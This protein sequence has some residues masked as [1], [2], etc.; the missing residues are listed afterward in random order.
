MKLYTLDNLFAKIIFAVLLL[1]TSTAF[2]Q[3]TD[4][5][6]EL[7][8]DYISIYGES[9]GDGV[10]A[11]GTADIEKVIPGFSTEEILSDLAKGKNI[12]SV[13]E[14]IGKGTELFVA[15]IKRTLKLLI[16]IPA[17][18][19]LGSYI[20]SMQD[21]LQIK[22]AAQASFFTCYCLIAGI[23]AAAFF[24]VVGCG[25]EIINNVSLF[26][27]VLVPVVLVSL[28]SSGAIVSA[29]MFEA[30]LV[31]VIEITQWLIETVFVPFVMMAAA[32][33]IVNNLSSGLNVEKLVQF[34]NKTVKW[35]LG[36]MLT[37]FVGITGLQGIAAGSADGLTV[38]VTKFAASNLIPMVGGI[39]S[40]TVETVMNC[41]VVI[42]NS[43]GVAGIVIVV[44]L[45]IVPLVKISA[46]LILFRL[47][48]ALVQPISDERTV[49]CLS[50]LGD[51]VSTVF[52]M[53]VAVVV[54]FV[55]ILTIMINIGNTAI[56]LGR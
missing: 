15:E 52:S 9:L 34:I 55:V 21:G 2:A 17:L 28:A 35:G 38:K 14:I 44:A 24:D 42:K 48:A 25:R 10:A 31:S 22:G 36:I 33:N 4:L 40:E 47:C 27:R 7:I 39:L 20:I 45:T 54:M 29:T 5:E 8:D 37:L 46:C 19:V 11:V 16:F 32:L 12:F 53:S 30:M 51:S 43:V 18:A 41:S 56:L 26:M 1:V 13:R 49:K 50:G 6:Y 3:S 23:A